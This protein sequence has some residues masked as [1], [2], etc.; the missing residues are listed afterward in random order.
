MEPG[1]GE[2]AAIGVADLLAT[3]GDAYRALPRGAWAVSLPVTPTLRIDHLQ[4]V[5]LPSSSAGVGGASV[6]SSPAQ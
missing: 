2:K 5:I 6:K 4:Q 3:T 1:Y